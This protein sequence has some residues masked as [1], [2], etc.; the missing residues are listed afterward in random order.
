MLR[1]HTWIFLGLSGCDALSFC[2]IST[3]SYVFKLSRKATS[4]RRR[5]PSRL[6]WLRG[7]EPK[8]WI[9]KI[10]KYNWYSPKNSDATK[11][12][13]KLKLTYRHSWCP[14]NERLWR[15]AQANPFLKVVTYWP[16]SFPKKQNTTGMCLFSSKFFF[17]EKRR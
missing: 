9:R 6:Y 7:K 10:F 15:T 14:L 8:S 2:I 3:I 12:Q 11:L 4:S 1:V 13:Q 5:R 16:R 17:S